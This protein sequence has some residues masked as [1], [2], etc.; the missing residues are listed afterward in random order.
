MNLLKETIDDI[1][2]SGHKIK[3]I[4]FIGS[5]SSGHQCTWKKFT[6]LADK[7]YD[8]GFGAQKVAS[9]L[10]IAFIDGSTMVRGEYDGSE[11]WDYSVPF[12][13]PKDNKK[14]KSLF[15]DGVGWEDLEEINGD[16]I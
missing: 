7:N 11:S 12:T 16:K 14:I 13:M 6:A 8:S 1:K 9:D 15:V 10:M 3:D 4:S 5:E 2:N